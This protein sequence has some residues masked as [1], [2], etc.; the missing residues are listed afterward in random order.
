M[1]S[2][3]MVYANYFTSATKTAGIEADCKFQLPVYRL[4]KRRRLPFDFW[5]LTWVMCCREE[6]ES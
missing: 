2:N 1:P 4:D 5:P 6:N 3:G